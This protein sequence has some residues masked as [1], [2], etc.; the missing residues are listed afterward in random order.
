MLKDK[1][2]IEKLWIESNSYKNFWSS[3]FYMIIHPKECLKMINFSIKI[4]IN[5]KIEGDF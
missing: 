2:F 4:L 1:L 3:Y 5:Y